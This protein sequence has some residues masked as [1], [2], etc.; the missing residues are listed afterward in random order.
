MGGGID[1]K[2]WEFYKLM[3]WQKV[4]LIDGSEYKNDLVMRRKM[5]NI[6]VYR[7]PTEAE[8]FRD[9]SEWQW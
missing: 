4:K 5:N 6:W 9:F 1:A 2:E 8:T 3:P 7:A